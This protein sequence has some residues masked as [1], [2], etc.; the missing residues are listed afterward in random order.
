MHAGFADVLADIRARDDR[1]SHRDAAPHKQA[2]DAIRLDTG[3]LDVEQAIAEAIR[4]AEERLS[5]A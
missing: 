5:A 3:E 2:D 1:D 4:L